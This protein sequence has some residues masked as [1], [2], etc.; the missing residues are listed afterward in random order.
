MRSVVKARSMGSGAGLPGVQCLLPFRPLAR[1]LTSLC[2]GFLLFQMELR[3]IAPCSRGSWCVFGGGCLRSSQSR[4]DTRVGSGCGV[5]AR[6]C[7]PGE[8]QAGWGVSDTNSEG[9]LAGNEASES[10]PVSLLTLSARARCASGE[11]G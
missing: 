7:P 6:S 3:R 10:F 2:L 11:R 8:A 1:G 4:A 5:L 9:G